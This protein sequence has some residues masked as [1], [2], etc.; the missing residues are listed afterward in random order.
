MNLCRVKFLLFLISILNV[1]FRLVEWQ[2]G[3]NLLLLSNIVAFECK[4]AN[5]LQGYFTGQTKNFIKFKIV[6]FRK[7]T[8]NPIGLVAL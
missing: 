7:E 3:W 8:P 5:S 4:P 6:V 2:A 1:G